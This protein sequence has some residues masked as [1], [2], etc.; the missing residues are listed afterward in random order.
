MGEPVRVLREDG[1]VDPAVDPHL[2]RSDAERLY[3][4]MM[5]ERILD[6]RMLALQRQGRIGFYGPSIGQEAA[7]VGAAMAMEANDWIVPQYR[8]P[9]AALARG[10]PLKEL[11]CQFMTNSGDPAKGRQ[12]PCHYVY[13]KGNFLSISS[14]VGTQIPHAVGIGWAMKL[15]KARDAVLV[16]FGDGATSTPDFHVSMNFAGVFGV[17]CVFLCNNN[18]W[19]IS[20]P[21]SRQTATATLAEKAQAYGLPSRRVDGMDALAVYGA[22]RTAA[23]AA[24]EGRGPTL[25]E[26]LSYRF[27]PHSSSDDPARYRDEKEAAVWQARDP[28]VR[29]RAYLEAQGGWNDDR[30]A[31]LEKAIGDEITQAVAEAEA[32]PPVPVESFFTEVTQDVPWNLQE[33][34]AEARSVPRG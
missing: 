8:E 21:V 24:R 23:I 15:R 29:F 12:M 22:T 16:Y 11:I 4:G 27:G 7:I 2:S 33:D 32:M 20:L 10:M 14:P 13:R 34:L 28:L 17:P 5:L 1:S 25:I 18:Q 6:N 9:G 30:E 31:A 26:S 3:R 19:A